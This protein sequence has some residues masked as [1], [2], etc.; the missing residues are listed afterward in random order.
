M[1]IVKQRVSCAVA[2]R[3]LLRFP[4]RGH[5][6][7]GFGGGE[8]VHLEE[9]R[10]FGRQTVDELVLAWIAEDWQRAGA[11]DDGD[12]GGGRHGDV[13]GGVFGGVYRGF[14]EGVENGL[15]RWYRATRG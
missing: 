6:D 10:D 3:D 14:I 12:D 2:D 1:V 15:G 11:V 8:G 13:D 9:G 5:E 7:D 4:V